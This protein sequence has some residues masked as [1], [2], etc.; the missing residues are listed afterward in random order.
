ML[1]LAVL[2]AVYLLHTVNVHFAVDELRFGLPL[3]CDG[4]TND[5]A[6]VVSNMS[7][8]WEGKVQ[9]FAPSGDQLTPPHPL[10]LSCIP[11]E[12]STAKGHVHL[13]P[14]IGGELEV[15]PTHFVDTF[16]NTLSPLG[17]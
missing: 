3:S 5:F 14:P 16:C 4:L 1:Y 15:S 10:R 8:I 6:G 17:V 9:N 12:S 11:L 2:L 13:E 7:R